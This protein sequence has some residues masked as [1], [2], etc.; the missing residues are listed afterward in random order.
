MAFCKFVLSGNVTWDMIMCVIVMWGF[1]VR[2]Y[3]GA[4]LAFYDS[5]IAVHHM[6]REEVSEGKKEHILDQVCTMEYIRI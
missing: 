4:Q 1:T 6:S 2:E 5:I 3:S